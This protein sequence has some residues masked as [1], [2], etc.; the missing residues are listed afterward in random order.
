MKTRGRACQMQRD[1]HHRMIARRAFRNAS[2]KVGALGV[3]QALAATGAIEVV[4]R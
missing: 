4:G 2:M 3:E 1:V